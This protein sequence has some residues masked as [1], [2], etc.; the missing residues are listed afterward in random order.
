[1]PVLNLLVKEIV[2]AVTHLSKE[3]SKANFF[4]G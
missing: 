1:M 2:S 3:I 4:F